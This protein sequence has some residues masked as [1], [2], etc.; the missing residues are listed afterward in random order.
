MVGRFFAYEWPDPMREFLKSAWIRAT[1]IDMSE[2]E[3]PEDEYRTV[4]DIFVRRLRPGLRPLGKA[5]IVSPA[6]CRVGTF[7]E[8][9]EDNS[10]ESVKGKTYSLSGF[11]TG[12]EI[13]S[14][15]AYLQS[16]K[17]NKENKLFYI[18]LYL[19]P[20]DCHRYFSPTNWLMMYRRHMTGYL[21]SVHPKYVSWKPQT[22]ETNERVAYL[23]KYSH[24]F[25]GFVP[26]GAF[27][28]G[29]IVMH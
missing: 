27:N 16:L 28:V 13:P 5:E 1:G 7:G 17:Q 15:K 23:G 10:I 6:D 2:A 22:F 25:F 29:S 19:A 3:R 26:V 18:T 21:R 20:Y 14:S 4:Q 12:H 9:T 8:L 11:L 24:G